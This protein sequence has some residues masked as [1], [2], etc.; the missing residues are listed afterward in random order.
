VIHLV[1]GES[2]ERP[3]GENELQGLNEIW[4]FAFVQLEQNTEPSTFVRSLRAHHTAFA[5]GDCA[6]IVQEYAELCDIPVL[7]SVRKP[8][9]AVVE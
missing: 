9:I 3:T 1:K 7:G 8:P 2:I 6:D 5:L 4:P